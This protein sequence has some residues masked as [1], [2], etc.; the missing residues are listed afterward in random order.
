METPRLYHSRAG[1]DEDCEWCGWPF[2]QGQQL[3]VDG[4]GRAFCGLACAELQHDQ[5]KRE[6]EA[7]AAEAK[8][9]IA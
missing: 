4:Q 2:D 1:R 5:D 8:G 6:A 7:D 3:V 9:R